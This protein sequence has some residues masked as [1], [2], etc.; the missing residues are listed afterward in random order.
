MATPSDPQSLR[1]RA[2]PPA[3]GTHDGALQAATTEITNLGFN[4][5]DRSAFLPTTP[6]LR[7]A[8]AVD[9]FWNAGRSG[10][11]NVPRASA[12]YILC[13][14]EIAAT[15]TA[16]ATRLQTESATANSVGVLCARSSSP[17]WSPSSWPSFRLSASSSSAAST[18][19]PPSSS[20][21]PTALSPPP[22]RNKGP[23]SVIRR[24]VAGAQA[25]GRFNKDVIEPGTRRAARGFYQGTK[26]FVK[27]SVNPFEAKRQIEN[28]K[29]YAFVNRRIRDAESAANDTAR[30]VGRAVEAS[31]RAAGAARG[32][33]AQ[34]AG[35][36]PGPR[37]RAAAAAVSQAAAVCA[38]GGPQRA[39]PRRHRRRRLRR[40]SLHERKRE[41]PPSAGTTPAATGA[42]PRA[43]CSRR[44]RSSAA[45]SARARAPAPSPAPSTRWAPL[46]SAC[47]SSASRRGR[48]R[49][50]RPSRPRAR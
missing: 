36:D 24:T 42:T 28:S 10:A 45:P 17:S 19:P 46:A 29:S 21:S 37:A 12:G 4:V 3:A 6:V 20:S 22:T 34:L 35:R 5:S 25:A 2:F 1:Q 7:G 43:R 11:S 49:G 16:A 23:G 14:I 32:G 15:Q 44:R 41:S 47:C 13:S 40:Q 30:E 9:A 26:N 50:R 31:N 18:P 8:E 27:A 38:R 33:I 39:A 48:R